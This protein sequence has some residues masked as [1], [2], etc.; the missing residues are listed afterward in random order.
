MRFYIT[1]PVKYGPDYEHGQQP[2]PSL[3]QLDAR[4]DWCEIVAPDEDSARETV[5]RE[6]G[7]AW[8]FLYTPDQW[9]PELY[10]GN[11]IELLTAGY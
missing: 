10:N 5:F 2:H 8:A 6:Y 3:P 4:H 11:R 7:S 1:F 9:V